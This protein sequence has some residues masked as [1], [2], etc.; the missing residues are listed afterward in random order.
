MVHQKL[1]GQLGS[2]GE[3]GS[4]EVSPPYHV[5]RKV[6]FIFFQER[7]ISRVQKLMPK[8]TTTAI[9]SLQ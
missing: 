9:L 7:E 2:A 1:Q 3:Q 6:A 8:G 5:R 4:P